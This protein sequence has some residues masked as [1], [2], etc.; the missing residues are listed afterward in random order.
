MSLLVCSW[1]FSCFTV[2]CLLLK[3]H[4]CSVLEW[5]TNA[6]TLRVIITPTLTDIPVINLLHNLL[7]YCH[8]FFPFFSG[9]HLPLFKWKHKWCVNSLTETMEKLLSLTLGIINCA[10]GDI[11]NHQ[12]P[13]F[14]QH[15]TCFV[16]NCGISLTEQALQCRFNDACTA[17]SRQ[18][19]DTCHFCRCAIQPLNAIP[20]G[21]HV[22]SILLLRTPFEK[23][24]GKL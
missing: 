22:G 16:S 6:S 11:F 24:P 10:H 7:T 12:Q 2:A 15:L 1:V 23:L 13:Y 18:E 5:V 14:P 3:W 20:L 19:N 8:I 21:I 4:I 17:T 9:A